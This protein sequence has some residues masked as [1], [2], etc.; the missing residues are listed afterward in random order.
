ML[1]LS[2][3]PPRRETWGSGS[4][5]TSPRSHSWKWQSWLQG[6]APGAFPPV[7]SQHP[8]WTLLRLFQREDPENFESFP[9]KVGWGRGLDSGLVEHW[10]PI[11]ASKLV[12][13]WPWARCSHLL[14]LSFP[15][16]EVRVELRP[17]YITCFVVVQ[18]L[19]C[20]QLCNPVDCSPPGFPVLHCLLEFA[21]THAIQL[22]IPSNHL[23]LCLP[24][25]HKPS[26]FPSIRV[27][28]T[29]SSL[30][31]RWPK[32]WNFTLASVL[33]VNIQGWMS[34]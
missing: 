1:E 12:A 9:R 13:V 31:V 32:Y 15:M 20:V 18:S 23:I 27:F 5:V 29:E 4:A 34:I 3:T 22:V 2:L 17:H 33:P 19:S 14:R 16:W 6:L 7:P 24:L 10:V 26:I 30:H 8:H 21:Q 11:L 25:L 28:S